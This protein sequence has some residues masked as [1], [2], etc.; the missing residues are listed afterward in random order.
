MGRGSTSQSHYTLFIYEVSVSYRLYIVPEISFD[1]KALLIITQSVSQAASWLEFDNTRP[2]LC[3]GKVVCYC[4][5]HSV[6]MAYSD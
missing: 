5:Y 4:E 1:E 2:H 3:S 6:E